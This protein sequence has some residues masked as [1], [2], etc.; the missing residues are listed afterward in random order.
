MFLHG[1]QLES[2]EE[3]NIMLETKNLNI[4]IKQELI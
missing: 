3:A 1:E 4:I 2:P